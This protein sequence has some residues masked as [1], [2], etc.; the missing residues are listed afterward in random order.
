ML[1]LSGLDAGFLSM[2]TPTTFGHVGGV[3]IFDPSDRPGG[4]LTLEDVQRLIA[5]RI[6][7]LPPYRRRLVAVPFGIDRPYWIED[8]DFDLDF[9]VRAI[10]LPSPGNREQLA[11]QVAR[12]HARPLDRTRPLWE[13][14][15]ISGLEDGTV[16][17]YT[18]THHA[19]IDGVSGTELMSVMLD[20][21]PGGQ[22]IEPPSGPRRVEPVPSSLELLGRSLATAITSPR[23]ALRMQRRM[24]RAGAVMTR[25]Q[26]GPLAL[27]AQEA[28]GRVPVLADLP[29][30]RDALGTPRD[31]PVLG[32]PSL[33]GPRVS[34]NRPITPHRRWAYTT[35]P[36]ADVRAIKQ[37][38]GVT[39]NDVMMAV[40]AGALRRFLADRH[41][42]PTTPL[43]AMTPVSVR[44]EETAGTYGNQVAGM[45][46]VL[47]T[48]EADPL[49]RL[50]LAHEAMKIAKEQYKALP[51]GMMA[52]ITQ[53]TPP[54]L[55]ALASRLYSRMRIADLA[56]PPFN[57]VIS[58]VPGPQH[59]LYAAGARQIGL[60]PASIVMDGLGLNISLV[61]Y[62]GG[63]HFGLL[64]CRELV[65]DLW[66][67]MDLH[68]DALAEL[69]KLAD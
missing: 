38:Y 15:L 64:A 39:V 40:S 26:G 22:P 29:F 23:R 32:R 57:V 4:E 12:I 28:L 2:E 11:E 51:A 21:T 17:M 5:E 58:N 66:D 16:A 44:T 47:P 36:F 45:I 31:A 61:S 30:V 35:V 52:D 46:A 62:D 6:H 65:P 53:F 43:L 19:A 18:K 27:T 69:R 54:A 41:E 42:L 13:L 20:T 67:L 25:Q 10:G 59:P 63:I 37:R 33:T 1:Q 50:E 60:Y 48:H 55:A 49:R 56:N 3:S 8:P 14:Y 9:H 7:L 24:L 68:V 34:F